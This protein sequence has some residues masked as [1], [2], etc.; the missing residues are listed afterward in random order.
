M[1]MSR[2]KKAVLSPL[3]RVSPGAMLSLSSASI[4]TTKALW[5]YCLVIETTRKFHN[6]FQRPEY[7]LKAEC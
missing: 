5:V 6:G 1:G 2:T 4:W 3:L 7:V